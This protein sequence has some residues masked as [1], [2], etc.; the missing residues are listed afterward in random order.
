[1]RSARDDAA[2]VKQPTAQ[3]EKT[4]IRDQKS[5]IRDKLV[6]LYYLFKKK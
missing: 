1:M 5:E 2:K 4:E 6:I 3:Q